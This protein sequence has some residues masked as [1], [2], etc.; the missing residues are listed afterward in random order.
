[1]TQ[2]L[3]QPHTQY[4]TVSQE[5]AIPLTHWVCP[6]GKWVDQLFGSSLHATAPALHGGPITIYPLTWPL[7][8]SSRAEGVLKV[9]LHPLTKWQNHPV[10]EGRRE[11]NEKCKGSAARYFLLTR[12]ETLTPDSSPFSVRS[13]STSLLRDVILVLAWL[14][15]LLNLVSAL[16]FSS[17]VC[18][19]SHHNY[20]F[21]SLVIS[22]ATLYSVAISTTL[23]FPRNNRCMG[24]KVQSIPTISTSGAK[25]L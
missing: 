13:L 19:Y 12:A 10:T 5:A 8:S 11:K 15:S 25:N 17:Y 2:G 1:M 3:F 6:R 18:M 7:T 16:E 23:C 9:R 21:H 22:I 24:Q 14:L 20:I 4:I